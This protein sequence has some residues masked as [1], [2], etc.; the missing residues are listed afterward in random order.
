MGENVERPLES[1]RVLPCCIF[2]FHYSDSPL[3][4]LKGERAISTIIIGGGGDTHNA[5]TK[6]VVAY[7]R[8]TAS[9]K[10]RILELLQDFRGQA[11][12]L[13]DEID[14]NS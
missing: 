5:V 11:E 6:L 9:Q 14:Q 12:A 13:I 1:G 4:K 3:A 2:V 10:A 7:P 8:A